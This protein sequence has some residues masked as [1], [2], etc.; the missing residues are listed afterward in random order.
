L[1]RR[2]GTIAVIAKIAP[3]LGLLG[4]V[5]SLLQ[6]FEF[7]QTNGPYADAADFS[8]YITSALVT[9]ATGLTI[10][11]MAYLAHHFLQGRVRALVHD[12][13]WVGN[14]MLQ[15]LLVDL[16]ATPAPIENIELTTTDG[17]LP[18]PANSPQPGA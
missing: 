14:D 11:I 12:M 9:T 15:F 6:G 18:N 4:T 8:A 2:L 13:E 7:M 1:E 5:L 3:L 16:P 10:A 17:Q